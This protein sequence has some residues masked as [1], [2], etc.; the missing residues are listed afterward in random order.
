MLLDIGAGIGYYSLAAA[1]RG[2]RVIAAELS[3]TSTA[4]IEASIKYTG[5]GKAI[6][7]H[8]VS[9][10]CPWQAASTPWLDIG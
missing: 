7:L 4:S 6:T 10:I 1:A 8:N 3:P 2:H 9:P 5:F